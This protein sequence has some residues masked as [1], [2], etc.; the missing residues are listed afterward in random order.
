MRQIC[1]HYFNPI[2]GNCRGETHPAY[3]IVNRI[4]KVSERVLRMR[5]FSQE[6]LAWKTD[7]ELGQ[8]SRIE[9]GVINTS[10]S[11]L[12]SIAEALEVPM[13]ALFEFE[14]PKID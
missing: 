6:A 11:Q 1:L 13:A 8:I 12:F 14:L 4:G 10:V 9:R 7:L 3:G 2:T 5:G